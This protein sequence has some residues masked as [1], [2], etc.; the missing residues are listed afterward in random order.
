MRTVVAACHILASLALAPSAGADVLFGVSDDRGKYD[1]DGGAWFYGELGEVGLVA[2]K[3]TV[4]WD[5]ANPTV[6]TE[7]PFIDRAIPQAQIRGIH[8]SFGIHIGKARAIT[9]DPDGLQK[10]AD[11]RRLLA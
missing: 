6:I 7:A 11:W 5:P 2:N 4:N 3:M 9:S 10:F 8:L 1:D